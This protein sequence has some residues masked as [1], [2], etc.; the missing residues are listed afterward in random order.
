MNK[1]KLIQT[2]RKIQSQKGQGKRE[3]IIKLYIVK[4]THKDK[5]TNK[6]HKQTQTK[7]SLIKNI[8]NINKKEQE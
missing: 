6:K 8:K 4:N 5:Q 3:R 2:K 7:K 1:Y